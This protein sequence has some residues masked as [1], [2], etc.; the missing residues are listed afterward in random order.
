[1]VDCWGSNNRFL[2]SG[3][4]SLGKLELKNN[5]MAY[6]KLVDEF[7][8]TDGK[9]SNA[10]IISDGKIISEVDIDLKTINDESILGVGNIEIPICTPPYEIRDIFAFNL[11]QLATSDMISE[12]VGGLEGY[13][14]WLE[15]IKKDPRMVVVNQDGTIRMECYNISYY[16]GEQ[17]K[18]IAWHF[19][20][21]GTI[22]C[23]YCVQ[24][25]YNVAEGTFFSASTQG[26]NVRN[27]DLRHYQPEGWALVGEEL[28]D[29]DPNTLYFIAPIYKSVLTNY[30][31]DADVSGALVGATPMFMSES[32]DNMA[33]AR[34]F[35]IPL[36]EEGPVEINYT[37]DVD[38]PKVPSKFSAALHFEGSANDEITMNCIFEVRDPETTNMLYYASLNQMNVEPYIPYDLISDRPETVPY[39]NV[40]LE[41]GTPSIMFTLGIP[42]A[43]LVEDTKIKTPNGDIAIKDIKEG[44]IVIDRDGNETKVIKTYSHDTTKLY[45]IGIEN[46]VISG[47]FDH[48]FETNY[49]VIP[50][51]NIVK[52]LELI[53]LDG[54]KKVLYKRIFDRKATVC[55]IKT[56]ANNYTLAN[57]VIC[58]CEDV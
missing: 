48:R 28:Y 23:A 6:E 51:C 49:G 39:Y 4:T 33:I 21:P 45:N 31:C 37:M 5:G 47:T 26:Y 27:T 53:T 25:N 14:E 38:Y 46:E 15:H 24:C 18:S 16:D 54:N 56:E 36:D 9:S 42:V 40:P 34:G 11:G 35:G 41:G 17:F 50:A 2:S 8:E 57:G 19:E 55:E 44:D 58:H 12:M 43:C 7:W 22:T 30:T 10:L 32:P 20:A 1:M 13:T 3:Q 52:D 29:A